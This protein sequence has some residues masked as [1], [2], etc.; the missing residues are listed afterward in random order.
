MTFWGIGG[1]GLQ[2]MNLESQGVGMIQP[3]KFGL[4]LST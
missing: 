2:T 4:G 1:L 3:T